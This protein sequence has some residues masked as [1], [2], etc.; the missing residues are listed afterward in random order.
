MTEWVWSPAA[1]FLLLLAASAAAA[2][3]P[4]IAVA[5]TTSTEESGLFG[6]LLP[7]FTKETGIQGPGRR[8]RHRTGTQDR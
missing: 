4:F 7:A 6:Y 5:S 8:G 3:E 2:Q 1:R